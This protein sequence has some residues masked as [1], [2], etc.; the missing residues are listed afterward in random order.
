MGCSGPANHTLHPGGMGL[1]S[2]SPGEGWGSCEDSLWPGGCR[3]APGPWW[4]A[5][6]REL[7][8]SRPVANKIAKK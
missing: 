6:G 4:E 2:H 3:K 7:P 1:T 5:G 8:P